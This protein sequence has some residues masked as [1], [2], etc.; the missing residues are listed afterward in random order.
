MKKS[1]RPTLNY[2][3]LVIVFSL[4]LSTRTAR[5]EDCYIA[6]SKSEGFNPETVSAIGLALLS[7]YLEML[8]P[9]PLSGI[10][11]TA[12]TY[13][14][15]VLKPDPNRIVTS[16]SGP[17][18]NGIGTTSLTG[19][20]GLQQSILQALLKGKPE[21]KDQICN[22]YGSSLEQECK[23]INSIQQKNLTRLL[24]TKECEKCNL[25][26]LTVR[27]VNL[28]RSKLRGANL[29][30]IKITQAK[31]DGADLQG[32]NLVGA[33]LTN[34]RLTKAN[35]KNA[36]LRNVEY[37]FGNLAKAD[38]RGANLE[39]AFFNK[40][41]KIKGANFSNAIW[42]DGEKCSSHSIGK[43]NK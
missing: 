43:C 15:S 6:V 17:D 25:S 9:I 19:V 26:G 21:S 30:N 31:A 23:E 35:L 13:E 29:E 42:F 18:L 41:V 1:Y 24:T 8:K 22:A 34:V 38:L 28:K 2:V 39:G 7:P 4:F 12:C 37:N 14:I 33:R 16:I 10:E 36:D 32:A 40:K 3:I 27:Q 20:P 5:A 11:E